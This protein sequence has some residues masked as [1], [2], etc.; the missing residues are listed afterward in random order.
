MKNKKQKQ[1]NKQNEYND[2]I[3]TELNQIVSNFMNNL[4][5]CYFYKQF[6]AIQYFSNRFE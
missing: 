2:N 4:Q 3:E 1:T 5:S 6:S